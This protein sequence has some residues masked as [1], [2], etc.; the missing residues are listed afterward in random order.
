MASYNEKTSK[1]LLT[2]ATDADND[3]MTVRRING[4][5][6]TSWPFTVDLTAG[7]VVIAEN[8]LVS[9]D[10][11]GTNSFHPTGGQT[12]PNGSFTFTLWDGIAE[13]EVYTATIELVGVN[14]APT[15]QDLTLTFEV[16]N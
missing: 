12:L 2:G 16:M 7:E 15:G 13:S 5:L 6:I 10:D 3:I 11:E 9:Y 4:T 8:G 1:T 14:T